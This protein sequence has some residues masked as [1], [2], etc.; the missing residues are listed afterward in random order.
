[1]PEPKEIELIKL[2]AEL[3]GVVRQAGE[4]FS[5]AVVA[6]YAYDL[7]KEFNQYYHDYPILKEGVSEADRQFRLSLASQVADTLGRA[8]GLLGIEMP[9]RM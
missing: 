5:P 8:M 2:L 3:A 9:E 1:M 7:A 6:A 4:E